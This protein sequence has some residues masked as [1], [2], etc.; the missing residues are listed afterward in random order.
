MNRSL[1]GRCTARTAIGN[2]A[3]RAV[4]TEEAE[5]SG[6]NEGPFEISEEQASQIGLLFLVSVQSSTTNT[7]SSL[8]PPSLANRT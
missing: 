4:M 3:H 1:I 8:G 5:T 6:D 7:V 2:G